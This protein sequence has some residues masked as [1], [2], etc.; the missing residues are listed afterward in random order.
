MESSPKGKVKQDARVLGLICA[1]HFLSHFYFLLLPP[2]FYWI[3]IDFGLSYTQLGVLMSILYA[4]A[5]IFQV[6]IGFL[7]DRIGARL[8]LTTGLLMM[9]V[10]FGLMGFASEYWVFML[11]AVIGSMG[12]SVFHP[13]DYTIL[14]S[15]IDQSRMGRAFS[16]HT[17]A[18]HMGS[19]AA[20]VI[21][22]FLAALW[23]WRVALMISGILGLVATLAL[24]TQ[25][26][27]LHD[28]ILPKKKPDAGEAG[29][30]QSGLALLMSKPILKFFMFFALLSMVAS[31]MY[32][33]SVV[34]LVEL[35]GMT[36]KWAGNALTA[37]LVLSAI[38]I[39]IGGYYA[40]KTTRHDLMAAGAFIACAIVITIVAAVSMPILLVIVVL[41]FAGFA[42]GIIRPARDM[43]VRAVAPK[44]SV[45]KVFGFVSAGIAAGGAISPTLFGY[46]MD[47]GRPE[48]VFYLMAI[49][50][51]VA[52]LTVAV[53]KQTQQTTAQA[54]E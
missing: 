30:V 6:P 44:G 9:S 17:F 51:V 48:W 14:N 11:L 39:L 36:V 42:Q 49:F 1:G 54:A 2:L 10:S 13:A 23:D 27:N 7:V 46:V 45:G 53:P 26:N 41:S 19:A 3:K 18:G 33:F 35:H 40:D 15:S 32:A 29:E 25:W 47:L 12:H 38:G 34:A 24:T 43:M 21:V 28:D 22:L 31:G 8:V 52:V 4:T 16:I 50:M 20:P 37:Y 5:G